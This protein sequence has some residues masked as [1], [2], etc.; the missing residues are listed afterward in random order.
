MGSNPKRVLARNHSHISKPQDASSDITVYVRVPSIVGIYQRV[1]SVF[2]C[3]QLCKI[4]NI[5]AIAYRHANH[6]GERYQSHSER[7][8]VIEITQMLRRLTQR[9]NQRQTVRHRTM[10]TITEIGGV[11]S[12]MSNCIVESQ[13]HKPT[14]SPLV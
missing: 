1:S 11:H 6:N 13:E 14:K 12:L 3:T 8:R 4:G 7:D 9:D 5:P 2:V 10:V